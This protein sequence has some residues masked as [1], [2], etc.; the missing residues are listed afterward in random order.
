[1]AHTPCSPSPV[2]VFFLTLGSGRSGRGSVYRCIFHNHLPMYP[3]F[4]AGFRWL[5]ISCL[6]C[7]W[8]SC[9]GVLQRAGLQTSFAGL[10]GGPAVNFADK[11]WGKCLKIRS[12]TEGSEIFSYIFTQRFFWKTS[13]TFITHCSPNSSFPSFF[14]LQ[15]KRGTV[16][17]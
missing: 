12:Q 14:I 7:T 17:R 10:P 9:H 11:L 16:Q 2:N 6:V 5:L 8:L 3:S 13:S 4:E 15:P 1:M